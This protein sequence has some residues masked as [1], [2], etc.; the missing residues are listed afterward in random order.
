MSYPKVPWS[1]WSSCSQMTPGK[2]AAHSTP[3]PPVGVGTQ[4]LERSWPVANLPALLDSGLQVA[5]PAASCCSLQDK[6]NQLTPVLI[7][8]TDVPGQGRR[9]W[10]RG[11]LLLVAASPQPITV[12]GIK[13]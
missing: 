9:G 4:G 2:A 1:T 11:P 13:N 8:L 12:L 5:T 10:P 6:W 7:D 3:Q